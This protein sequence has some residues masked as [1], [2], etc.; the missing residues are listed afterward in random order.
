M[1]EVLM[2]Q[3][4]MLRMIPRRRSVTTQK[5]KEKLDTL[6]Y[7]ATERTIQRD[8]IE[9]SRK[10]PIVCKDD[11]KPYQWSWAI[12]GELWDIP[13]MDLDE[14]LPAT[15]LEIEMLSSLE[16]TM[17]NRFAAIHPYL[18][19][20][21]L[22]LLNKIGS[23][24]FNHWKR[25][26]RCIDTRQIA[27]SHLFEKSVL[28]SIHL[29]IIEKK[30]I[31]ISTKDNPELSIEI[32]VL[33]LLAIDTVY[34]MIYKRSGSGQVESLSV[35]NLLKA[36]LSETVITVPTNLDLDDYINKQIYRADSP[37]EKSKLILHFY[38]YAGDF[39]NDSALLQDKIYPDPYHQFPDFPVKQKVEDFGNGELRVTATKY[40]TKKTIQWILGL[41]SDVLVIEPEWLRNEIKALVTKT[42]SHYA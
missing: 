41:G 24:S 11:E 2:R 39:L 33:A 1:S 31:E 6:G 32:E 5:L 36:S 17:D 30:Y 42:A 23:A 7:Y 14:C 29:G 15:L 8:L 21:F 4:E 27:K 16:S 26:I 18:E 12:H 28:D 25:K 37:K 20:S 13:Q 9:M 38:N 22:F 35:A 34:K 19:R 40:V 10:L 3:I